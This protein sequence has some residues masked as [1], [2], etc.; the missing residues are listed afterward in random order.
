MQPGHNTYELCQQIIANG[1]LPD[2]HPNYS[3]LAPFQLI[4]ELRGA[5]TQN[6][7]RPVI[8]AR[9][10]YWLYPTLISTVAGQ[11]LYPIPHRASFGGLDRIEIAA[12]STDAFFPLDERP[13]RQALTWELPSGQYG[14]PQC[15]ELRG[16]DIALIPTP[17]SANYVLRVYYA[18]RPNKLVQCQSPT[19]TGI[20][21]YLDSLVTDRGRITSVANIASR[22]VTVNVIPKRIEQ[23]TPAEIVSGTD[24]VDVIRPNGWFMPVL[25]QAP[26]TFSGTVVTFGGSDPVSHL[27]VGDYLRAADETDWPCVPADFHRLIADLATITV[28]VQ[29]G[30][31]DKARVFG[32]KCAGDMDR[33]RDLLEP[34]V[35]DQAQSI[36]F[37]DHLTGHA[38]PQRRGAW[39]A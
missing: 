32:E 10:G 16:N 2:F 11:T 8:N 14:T 37:P 29:L 7:Q 9:K 22:Q 38:G 20:T 39:G 33:F 27:Q 25:V 6:I 17:D 24:Y 12:S 35:K 23:T 26:Q 18:V 36:D 1:F 21:T 3:I 34:R 4:R 30:H 15:Y 28:L 19:L 31:L 13:G 5:M